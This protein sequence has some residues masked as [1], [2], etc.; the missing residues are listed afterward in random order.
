MVA[1]VISRISALVL[2]VAGIALLFAPDVVL[3][4]V[5]PAFPPSA[6]WVGQLLA[7]AW[8]GVAVLNWLQRRAALGGI[9]G[10]PTV[11]ANL[12]L[13]FISALSLLRAAASSAAPV[14]LWLTAVVAGLLAA[15]Y[16]LLLLRGP[17]G[18][19]EHSAR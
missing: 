12:A 10:R 15:A 9:Y 6:A 14:P 3:P 1:S 11:L 17:F 4:S 7:A 2:C 8:L 18:T 16:A 13:Y 5:L 19:P